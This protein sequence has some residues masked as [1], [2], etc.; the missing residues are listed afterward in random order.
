[1]KWSFLAAIAL[2]LSAG[3]LVGAFHPSESAAQIAKPT[4]I[5]LAQA[6]DWE[7]VARIDPDRPVQIRLVN[8]AG[9]PVEYGLT[10]NNAAPRQLA[11]GATTSI[12]QVSA[13]AYMLINPMTTR[14][15]L[16]Y[17]ITAANNVVNV[18]ILQIDNDLPGYST[19]NI[20]WGGG[21][22]VY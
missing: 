3:F 19:F 20:D 21:I 11:S 2:P 22:Y 1:M 8:R 5:I 4:R 16:S 18:E 12:S 10:D 6:S 15:N 13:P 14:V 9:V 17:D 7:P